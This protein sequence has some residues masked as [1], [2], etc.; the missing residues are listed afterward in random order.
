MTEQQTTADYWRQHTRSRKCR[1][2]NAW[3][4]RCCPLFSGWKNSKSS[5]EKSPCEFESRLG[6]H[7]PQEELESLLISPD[8]GPTA[9][10]VLGIDPAAVLRTVKGRT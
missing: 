2:V 6:H 4:V 3:T 8:L 5:G 7:P 1:R 9:L 10:E